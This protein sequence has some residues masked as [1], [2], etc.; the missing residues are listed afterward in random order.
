MEKVRKHGKS[1][2]LERQ[3]FGF[4][5]EGFNLDRF[6]S[7]RALH[8]KRGAV[9]LNLG[10][11]RCLDDRTNLSTALSRWLLA[12]PSSCINLFISFFP[13]QA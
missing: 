5:N 13:L 10:T 2:C 11:P 7:G 8:V 4:S 1:H 12:G 9:T 3:F 6:K